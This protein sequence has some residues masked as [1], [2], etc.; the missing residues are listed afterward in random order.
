MATTRGSVSVGAALVV[1]VASVLL[2]GASGGASQSTSQPDFRASVEVVRLNVSVQHRGRSTTLPSFG[3]GDFI[4]EEDGVP[5]VV[6]EVS[7]QPQPVSLCIALDVSSSMR[8][9]RRELGAEAVRTIF[10]VLEPADE[11]AFLVFA[12]DVAVPLRWISPA[13]VPGLDWAQWVM[14]DGTA[15]YD[16]V[17]A[18]LR[19]MDTASRP[20]R[21]VVVVSDGE[22]S[23]STV[24]LSSLVSTRRQSEAQVFGFFAD[25]PNTDRGVMPN[26]VGARLRQ[27]PRQDLGSV[28]GDSG[29]VVYSIAD[30]DRIVAATLSLIS[31]L[32]GQYTISYR[33]KAA[34]D[35]KYHRIR[36]RTVDDQ[37]RVRHRGGY[38]AL[39]TAGRP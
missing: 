22:E 23:G 37:Y 18:A 15:L 33:P 1:A 35:G 11:V 10:S 36:V 30:S 2:H 6:D 19:L 27:P 9:R 5:Q 13:T 38:L 20:Q 24:E 14:A 29:G 3:P 39:P 31:D 25:V 32:R 8:F 4:V 17:R 26:E 16:G 7:H 28:V 21:A 12:R 34:M